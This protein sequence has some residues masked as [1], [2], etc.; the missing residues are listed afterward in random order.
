M[1][2][3]I[4]LLRMISTHSNELVTTDILKRMWNT[5]RFNDTVRYLP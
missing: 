1:A 5:Y 3:I 4:I 2:D